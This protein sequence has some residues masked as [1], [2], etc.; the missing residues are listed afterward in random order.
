[1]NS[2]SHLKQFFVRVTQSTQNSLLTFWLDKRGAIAPA[3]AVL[4]PV[5]ISAVGVSVDLSRA[6]LVHDRLARALDAAALAAGSTSGNNAYITKRF[7]DFFNANYPPGT[8]GDP[9]DLN[10][11]TTDTQIIVSASA[12]VQTTFMNIVGVDHITVSATSTVQKDL[13]GLEVALV[14]DNTGSLW[15][16]SGGKTNIKA[17]KDSATAFVNILYDRVSDASLV[18]IAIVPYAAE[19]N[20]GSEAPA[21]TNDPYVASW[22]T[23]KYAPYST[24]DNTAWSGCVLE[25]AYPNDIQDTS[26]AV[27]GK[28]EPF[29]W[30]DTASTG[31]PHDNDW[32]NNSGTLTLSMP[33][34]P[35]DSVGSSRNS[36]TW[37]HPNLG[38][39][40]PIIPLQS[41]RTTINN[42]IAKLTAWNRGGTV[43]DVGLAWG[44]RVLSPEPPFT[45]GHAWDDEAWS[46]ILVLMTDGDNTVYCEGTLWQSGCNDTRSDFTAY[47]RASDNV[48]G[49][50]SASSMLT[51]INSR[52][53]EACTYAKSKGITI[54]TITFSSSLNATTRAL[55]QNCATDANKYYNAPTQTDLQ[56]AFTQISKELSNLHIAQ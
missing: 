45:Q 6:Y 13:R 54:Y 5:V 47:K 52:V 17:V 46:K 35:L 31:D 16:S 30:L 1:M 9:F 22:L 18:D 34:G 3:L 55:W 12:N 25:R 36:N 32:R 26:V 42:E 28:W 2:L 24:T 51:K 33:S 8:L 39:P 29:R 44:V 38:C 19:V 43:G 4:I 27:G 50:T 10:I 21:I 48:M 53:T 14:L 49:T 15:S 23:T 7:N 56:N 11:Q 20:P 37:K 41:G 40:T